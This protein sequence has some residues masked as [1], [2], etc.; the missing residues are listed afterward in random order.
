MGLET[1]LAGLRKQYGDMSILKVG[2][3]KSLDV[4]TISTGCISLDKGL[5]AG[6]FPK[7]RIVELYGAPSCG[8]STLC[9]QAIAEVQKA[10][11]TAAYIDA[12]GSFDP[13]YAKVLGVDVDELYICQPDNGE[14]GLDICNKLA[15]SGEVDLVVV[16]SIPALTPK[17]VLEGE[18]GD[19]HFALQARMMSQGISIISATIKKSKTIVIFINQIRA[20]VSGYGSST[21]APGGYAIKHAAS[22]R[23]EIIKAEQLKKGETP[24]GNK[25]K[26]KVIKN[27]VGTPLKVME[28]DMIFG[29]GLSPEL[30]LI[31]EAVNLDIVEKSGAFYK[32]K[33]KS[34]GQG[35]E[36]ARKFLIDN[37]ETYEEI[38]KIVY[39]NIFN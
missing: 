21:T 35:R 31:D 22:V 37:K 15:A 34:I 28:L 33:G 26:I 4:E 38:Y 17:A 2:E 5:G 13:K 9:M 18:M 12:E 16:D 36:A 29:E 1:T 19:S 6:G 14:Q 39:E 11:G 3:D 27:K 25:T 10:G 20:N 30:S 8:K 32:Y 23:L 7:G 24:Y